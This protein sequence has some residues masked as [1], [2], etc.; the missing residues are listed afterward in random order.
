MANVPSDTEGCARTTG[1]HQGAFKMFWLHFGGS[2]MSF[3]SSYCQ[4]CL[5][6]SVTRKHFLP[7]RFQFWKQFSNHYDGRFNQSY[8]VNALIKLIPVQEQPSSERVCVLCQAKNQHWNR[9]GPK[10]LNPAAF[11]SGVTL[12]LF[13]HCGV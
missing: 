1:G 9:L 12:W 13:L 2:L 5:T 8:C 11:G 3:I 7:S 6:G 4:W 10:T